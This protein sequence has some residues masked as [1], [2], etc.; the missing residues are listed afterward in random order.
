M[1][2][3]D[4]RGVPLHCGVPARD[5]HASLCCFWDMGAPIFLGAA[6]PRFFNCEDNRTSHYS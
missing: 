5:G 2:N 4:I 3:N 1:K 6:E